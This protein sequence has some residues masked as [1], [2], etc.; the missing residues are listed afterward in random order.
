M[1]LTVRLLESCTCTAS[2]EL[3][4]LR[5]TR[6]GNKEGAIIVH[7][8]LLDLTLGCLV[9][10]FLVPGNQG[11]CDGL[12]DGVDLGC[13]TTTLNTDADVHLTV[14]VGS[15]EE[16]WLPDLETECLGLDKLDWDTVDLDEANTLL[17][18]CDG[19]SLALTQWGI[20]AVQK[21]K[22]AHPR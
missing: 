18:K 7:E 17:H 4:G 14:S 13:V 9:D 11:L 20:N 12:T 2:T 16:H 5:A 6:V 21:V 3:L 22:F 15:E 8:D 1:H 10:I 19:N